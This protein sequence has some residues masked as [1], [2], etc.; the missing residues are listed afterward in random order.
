MLR[1]CSTAL[2]VLKQSKWFGSTISEFLT[3][4]ARGI[5]MRADINWII[6]DIMKKTNDLDKDTLMSHTSPQ[7]FDEKDDR[8]KFYLKIE[9]RREF[10]VLEKNILNL[11]VWQP[12]E[13]SIATKLAVVV[14]NEKEGQ[15][16]QLI[17]EKTTHSSKKFG[18]YGNIAE[19]FE[20]GNL[21]EFKNFS[22]ISVHFTVEYNKDDLKERNNPSK[23]IESPI[24]D[25]DRDP[26]K[27][28][29]SSFAGNKHF[30]GDYS[31][32][33]F[34]KSEI[35][36]NKAASLIIDVDQIQTGL[37]EH[38][39]EQLFKNQSATD[40]C[41]KIGSYRLRA[42]KL[43]LSARSPVFTTIIKTAEANENLK[44]GV[45]IK[46]MCED[47]LYSTCLTVE[48]CCEKFMTTDVNKA[49]HLKKMVVDFI[50]SNPAEVMKTNGWI[51]LKKSNPD[52][53]FEVMEDILEFRAS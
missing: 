20:I 42:H 2:S 24:I 26:M 11:Y 32:I 25:V 22:T 28:P 39:L 14:R 52:L 9:S 4:E 47:F 18:L 48:N 34:K 23:Q 36:N 50:R 33:D 30:I 15:P 8:S 10:Y 45:E 37:I 35:P 3:P 29:V 51:K 1:H 7:F 43:I 41:F 46:N 5:K 40:I 44:D 21:E 49:V 38:D 12:N 31:K 27:L 6:P 53:A 19:I 13:F 16:R 17:Y